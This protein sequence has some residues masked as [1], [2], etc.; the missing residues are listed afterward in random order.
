M[1]FIFFVDYSFLDNSEF[2]KKKSNN[3]KKKT[4]SN[5]LFLLLKICYCLLAQNVG[6]SCI[7]FAKYLF[8]HGVD[9]AF[10]VHSTLFFFAFEESGSCS[11]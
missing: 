8:L 6:R 10:E 2:K 3:F 9:E 4:T 11:F 7:V 1:I 5:T